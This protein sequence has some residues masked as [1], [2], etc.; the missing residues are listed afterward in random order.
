MD[1]LAGLTAPRQFNQAD[2]V[3][4]PRGI[5]GIGPAVVLVLDISKGVES[6]LVA[7][8]RDIEAASAG[9]LH[10]RRH[11]VEFNAVLMGVSYPQDIP[12]IPFQTSE[13]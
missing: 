1:D 7:R 12:L 3:A 2:H 13:C 10:S 6:F 8:R 9:Q 5:F 4:S 11:E